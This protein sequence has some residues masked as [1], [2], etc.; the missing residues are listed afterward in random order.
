[1]VDERYDDR[2]TNSDRINVDAISS[3]YKKLL[4]DNGCFKLFLLLTVF[5]VSF[6]L[7][8]NRVG[9]L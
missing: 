9:C 6:D 3:S 1:M 5:I 2:R 7:Q 4:N 8:T